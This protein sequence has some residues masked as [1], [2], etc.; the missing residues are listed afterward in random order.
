MPVLIP[1]LDLIAPDDNV[2]DATATGIYTPTTCSATCLTFPI[3]QKAAKKRQIDSS[4]ANDIVSTATE[5]ASIAK[6]RL[7]SAN[8][9]NNIRREKNDISKELLKIEEKK[10]V[11]AKKKQLV[12]EKNQ[13]VAEKNQIVA[14]KNQI[15]AK[16]KQVVDEEHQQS[17]TQMNDM[18]ML[19]QDENLEDPE[20]CR[21]ILLIKEQI[22]NK[23][24]AHAQLNKVT[25]P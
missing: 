11:L 25:Y 18:K 17:E 23:W 12:D 3:G 6:D 14:K 5:L 15:V 8:Q 1:P 4:K 22:K 19:G 9:G 10:L 20:A 16:K 21:V 13:I 2:S 24:L 7:T